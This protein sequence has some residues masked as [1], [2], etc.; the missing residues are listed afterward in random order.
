MS[1]IFT[2]RS[3]R[4]GGKIEAA[5]VGRTHAVKNKL[6]GAEALVGGDGVV[7]AGVQVDQVQ[8][9]GHRLHQPQQVLQPARARV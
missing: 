4:F 5:D 7:G 2:Y 9:V 6:V 8:H 3:G 1:A